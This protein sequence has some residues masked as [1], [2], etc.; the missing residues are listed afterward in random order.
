MSTAAAAVALLFVPG[1]R[2]DRF[3]TAV[4]AQPDAIVLDLEDAVAPAEK[5]AAREHV[6]TYLA[7]GQDAVV[8]I[9]AVGTPWHEDDMAMVAA[10]GCAVMLPKAEDPQGVALVVAALRPATELIPLVETARGIVAAAEVCA[11]P[12]VVRPAFGSVDLA[13]QL[14]V[15]QTAHDGLSL[16]RQHLVIAAAA[17]G[18][19]GPL[20]GVTTALQDDAALRAD[21]RRAVALGFTGKLCV[22]PRQVAAVRDGFR[23]SPDQVRWAESVVAASGSGGVQVVAGSM[24]DRPVVERARAML[25][26]AGTASG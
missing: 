5:Q 15:D 13:A 24:V 6:R 3:P 11:V 26:R 18:I 2:P 19:A 12:G 16:A 9:N 1:D 23:P 20:D 22:H 4:A 17:A 8:R 21:V 10:A 14:G 7:T 25:A